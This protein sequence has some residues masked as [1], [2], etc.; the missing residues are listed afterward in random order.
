MEMEEPRW[1]FRRVIAR[2]EGRGT[3]TGPAE[4][5][6]C[7]FEL[8]QLATGKLV[9]ACWLPFDSPL[10]WVGNLVEL[11]GEAAA[12]QKVVVQRGRV[13]SQQP[14]ER[15]GDWV[16]ELKIS[17][18]KATV[19]E[20]L[21]AQSLRYGLT[22]LSLEGN[23]SY[24]ED[25]PGGGFRGGRQSRFRLDGYEVVIRSLPASKKLLDEIE[26][27]RGIGVT[28][29]AVVVADL[30]QC[31]E[32]D[33]L[34]D[35]L[36]LLLS[37]GLGRGVVWVYRKA[38]HREGHVVEIHHRSAVTKAWS[39]QGLV[40]N[41]CIEAFVAATYPRFVAAY[42]P[43]GLKNAIRAYNDALLEGDYLEFRALKLAVVMEYLVRRYREQHRDQ[44]PGARRTPTRDR[45]GKFARSVAG[46]CSLLGLPMSDADLDLVT[47]ARNRLVH[48]ATFLKEESAPSVEEQWLFLLTLIGRI[49]LAIVGYRGDWYDWRGASDGNG[50]RRTV[51]S[52]GSVA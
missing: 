43:W 4:V 50:P 10:V 7:S 44:P 34:M 42:E 25:L 27:T 23:E 9:M 2:Y 41:E 11:L 52:P 12:S 14:I 37:L 26:A 1:P 22:N 8:L 15:E 29:E 13:W 24:R 30:E 49:L 6:P 46:I 47:K 40:P 36:C 51:V 32:V 31:Q 45:R 17:C 21:G 28:A 18:A 33:E 16:N 35:R 39:A 19:G 48:E 20:S 38:L 3:L 5:R